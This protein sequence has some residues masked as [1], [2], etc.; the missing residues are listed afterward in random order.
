MRGAEDVAAVLAQDDPQVPGLSSGV[1]VKTWMTMGSPLAFIKAR[2][3]LIPSLNQQFFLRK[4]PIGRPTIHNPFTEQ[5]ESNV[6]DWLNFRHKLDPVGS[7]VPLA[8]THN[9]PVFFPLLYGVGTGA[10][11][12]VF[13]LL[14]AL[15]AKSVG[16]LFEKVGRAEG[17]ARRITVAVFIAAGIFFTL[18]Y[19]F[20]LF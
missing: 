3:K 18:R 14:I 10:P 6:T 11:A 4:Q 19:T 7:L 16:A 5:D 1:R 20:E 15:G 17:V 9:A 8:L 13:A 2:Q 12:A